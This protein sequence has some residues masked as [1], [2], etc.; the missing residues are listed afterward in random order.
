MSKIALF[1]HVAR[2]V[3][4]LDRDPRIKQIFDRADAA[5]VAWQ[6]DGSS[7]WAARI[8]RQRRCEGQAGIIADHLGPLWMEPAPAVVGRSTQRPA[9]VNEQWTP[10]F[11]TSTWNDSIVAATRRD[12][13][14]GGLP[15][16]CIHPLVTPAGHR[17]TDSRCPITVWHRGIGSRSSS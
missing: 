7:Y 15:K 13:S 12:V 4:Q 10:V 3:Y 6:T 1:Q 17:L 11:F 5:H 14:V 8:I 9:T 2:Y 16:A